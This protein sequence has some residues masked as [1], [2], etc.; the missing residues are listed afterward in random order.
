MYVTNMHTFGRILSTDNYQMNHLH[1]DL[2]QIFENPAVRM[3]L[4]KE[5]AHEI[6][7]QLYSDIDRNP[8][9]FR[10]TRNMCSPTFFESWLEA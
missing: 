4:C 10:H 2:W 5:V 8:T 9:V 7:I 6:E 1:N 3:E